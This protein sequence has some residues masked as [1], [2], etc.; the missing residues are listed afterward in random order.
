[1]IRN[2]VSILPLTTSFLFLTSYSLLLS[3][4]RINKYTAVF[5][6]KE[7]VID[8][9]L[10]ERVWLRA[11]KLNEFYEIKT[12][13][14]VKDETVVRVCYDKDNLYIAFEC[15]DDI[16]INNITDNDGPVYSDDACEVFIDIKGEGKTYFEFEVNPVNT[17]FDAYIKYSQ[18]IDFENAIKWDCKELKTASSVEEDYKHLRWVTEIKIPLKS[19]RISDN[20]KGKKWAINFYRIDVDINQATKYYAWSKT[21]NWFHEPECFGVIIF[22]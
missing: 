18:K 1:M 10:D 16:L 22:K 12:N 3:A 2:I 5:T 8:G 9:R 6:N 11:K 21:K 20:I 15:K 19:L 4:T 7:I 14:K 13:K 17:V